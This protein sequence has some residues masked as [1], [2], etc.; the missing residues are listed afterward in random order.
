[1]QMVM[2]HHLLHQALIFLLK[3]DDASRKG[4]EVHWANVNPFHTN[5]YNVEA[6]FYHKDLTSIRQSSGVNPFDRGYE[7]NLHQIFHD[8]ARF[9]FLR[10]RSNDG[11]SI[12]ESQ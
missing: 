4:I 5:A 8:L 9:E 6:Y 11:N 3:Y 7:E 1:M 12:E 2:C 10:S